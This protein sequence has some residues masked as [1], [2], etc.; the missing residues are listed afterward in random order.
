MKQ[1]ARK[2]ESEEGKS[3]VRK[4]EEERKEWVS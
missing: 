1:T 4:T 2:T 3:Q